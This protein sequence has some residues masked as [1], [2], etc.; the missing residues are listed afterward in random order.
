MKYQLEVKQ[1]VRFPYCR[2][3]REMVNNI[4]RNPGIHKRGSGLLFQFTILF[5]LANYRASYRNVEGMKILLQAGEWAAKY[6][7]LCEKMS[8]KYHYQLVVL[9]RRLQDMHLIEFVDYPKQKI[10]KFKIVCWANSNTTLDYNAPCQ[11]DT[12][13]F[14][15][16]VSLLPELLG[17][18]RCSEADII[19]DLWLNAVFNDDEVKC[20]TAAPV[21][22]YR[23][24]TGLPLVNFSDLSK[25]WGISKSTVHRTLKKFSEQQ[26]VGLISFPGKTGSIVYLRNYLS[27]M[28][29]VSDLEPTKEEFSV[30]LRIT[31]Q[32][33][34]E[35]IHG[36]VV[37]GTLSGVSAEC[38]SV[39]NPNIRKILET[40][41]KALFASGF[42][43]CA[44][45]HALYRLSTLSDCK[46]GVYHYDLSIHCGDSSPGY[47][48]SLTLKPD[49]LDIEEVI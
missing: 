15:F 32:G 41:R 16:P 10:V 46:G 45:P 28:F 39:P 23:N 47:C 29:C 9:L 33:D 30:L 1:L 38:S 24:G 19:M 27:T 12:G 17:T 4:I 43:C 40:T 3:Y 31:T 5:S 2:I 37:D 36:D 6:S 14:F 18:G 21:V 11:K 8:L 25:R 35:D 13:F 44:C 26:L 49:A 48:F 22:Y 34:V 42:S 20:S 7:E